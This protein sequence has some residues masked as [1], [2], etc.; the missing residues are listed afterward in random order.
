MDYLE[1]EDSALQALSKLA[2]DFTSQPAS[3][4]P[5]ISTSTPLRKRPRRR[6]EASYLLRLQ[7]P[8]S[9][10]RDVATALDLPRVPVLEV[11]DAEDGEAS[12][13]RL[14]QPAINT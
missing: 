8:L 10:P 14:S 3:S 5:F 7:T 2:V 11:G 6:V 9:T 12:F 13:C 1:L 4:K